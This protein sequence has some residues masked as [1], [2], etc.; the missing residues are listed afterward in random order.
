MINSLLW[1]PLV[2]ALAGLVLPK[3]AVGWW[4]A[5]GTAVTLGVA[6]ATECSSTNSSILHLGRGVHR[7]HRRSTAAVSC[8]PRRGLRR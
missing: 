2:F 8:A 4:A 1:T 7:V 3:R 6:I 5:L